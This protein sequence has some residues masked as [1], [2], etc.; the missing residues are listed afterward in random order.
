[1]S[2]QKNQLKSSSYLDL[3]KQYPLLPITSDREEVAAKTLIE[4]LYEIEDSQG[5]TE[6]QKK[7]F[8]VLIILLE[9]YESQKKNKSVPDIYG[10]DLL[11]VLIKESRLRQKDLVS[12]FRTESIVSEILK[13]KGRKLTVEHIQKLA[14]YFKC[15]PSAF[16]PR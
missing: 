11:K 14:D 15:S 9:K 16:F 1:M 4:D 2:K 8:D 7:Y 12:I 10:V 3:V 5:L 6:E 13:K